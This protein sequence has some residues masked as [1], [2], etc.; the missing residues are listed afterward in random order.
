MVKNPQVD[1]EAASIQLTR[2]LLV[3]A[4]EM[5]PKA[6]KQFN[7][8]KDSRGLYA[9]VALSNMIRE[10][11]NDLR[12]LSDRSALGERA[13]TEVIEPNMRILAQAISNEFNSV[14]RVVYEHCSTKERKKVMP[15][16]DKSKETLLE[17]IGEMNE[18]LSGHIAKLLS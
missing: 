3:M 7:S 17:R 4:V 11:A 1:A 9:T 2:T 5:L 6:E 14:G 12:A 15:A 8:S 18:G 10:I 16:L 13:S